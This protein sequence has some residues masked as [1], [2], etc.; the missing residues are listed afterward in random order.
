MGS[1]DTDTRGS[2]GLPARDGPRGPAFEGYPPAE[3]EAAAAPPVTVSV[4]ARWFGV[5][6][7]IVTTIIGG[8]VVVVLLFGSLTSPSDR[9]VSELLEA[10]EQSSGNASLGVLLPREKELWQ[11]AVELSH[12]LRNKSTEL[13][14][15]QIDEVVTRLTRLVDTDLQGLDRFS[16]EGATRQAQAVLRSDRLEWILRALAQ[17]RRTGA[18]ECLIAVVRRGVEPYRRVAMREL[19]DLHD[20][21]ATAGAVEPIRSVLD[22]EAA[23]ETLLVACTS[24]SVLAP[25]GDAAS[26]EALDTV[27]IGHPGEV[28]W[29]ASLALARLGSTKGNAT[30]LD[31]LDRSFWE[32][33]ERVEIV[34][35]A[36]IVHRYPMPGERIEQAMVAAIQAAAGVDDAEVREAVS[37]LAKDRSLHVRRAVMDARG[38]RE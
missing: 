8:A 25:V 10:L 12:R 16:A 11:T 1:D 35:Q 34:D 6:L 23:P 28:A 18:V 21:P 24:L 9:T 15:E 38:G 7:L 37:R 36:G 32:D 17:T 3:P 2:G 30:L 14:D 19:A 4:V 13:T 20:L 26:I 22:M 5:P 29:S 33:P 27:R 31:L